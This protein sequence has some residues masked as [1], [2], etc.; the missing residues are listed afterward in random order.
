MDKTDRDAFIL[1][2]MGL[3]TTIVNKYVNSIIGHQ[4]ICRE[5]L[6]SIGTIGLIKACDRFDPT[7]GLKFSS[8]AVPTIQGEIQTFLRDHLDSIKFT[9]NAKSDCYTIINEDLINENIDVISE[10]LGIPTKRVKSALGYYKDRQVEALDKEIYDDEEKS[11]TLAD[12]I[13]TEFDFDTN[14]ELEL[15]LNKLDDRSRKIV[16]LKIQGYNQIEISEIIGIS[17]A[18]VGRILKKIKEKIL[19][20]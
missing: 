19:L 18:Q 1:K 2:N 7:Y 16:E 9:R 8:Y 5:D 3:V 15:F 6:Q 11:I 10:K 14:L 20:M 12:T 17:Q 13:G 4:F